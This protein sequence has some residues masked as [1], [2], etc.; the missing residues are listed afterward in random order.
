MIVSLYKI[1]FLLCTI[2]FHI[3]KIIVGKQLVQVM[4]FLTTNVKQLLWTNCSK[5]DQLHSQLL[6]DIALNWWSPVI[7][8]ICESETRRQVVSIYCD[9]RKNRFQEI[10]SKDVKLFICLLIWYSNCMQ[11]CSCSANGNL[12]KWRE[13]YWNKKYETYQNYG[14]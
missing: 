8:Q 9:F 14:K 2:A 13:K 11:N 12:K 4:C 10:V 7:R 5:L 1:V 6:T 3:L